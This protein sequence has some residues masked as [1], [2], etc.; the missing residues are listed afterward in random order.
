[1]KSKPQENNYETACKNCLFAIYDGKTQTS[2]QL[3]R[4]EKFQDLDQVLDAYDDEK[5]FFVVKGICNAVRESGWNNDVA[6]EGKVLSEIRPRFDVFVDATG[7]T[8]K[9][10]EDWV[11]FHK[12]VSEQDFTIDWTVFAPEDISPAGRKIVA[13]LLRET[14]MT[15]VETNNIDY[16]MTERLLQSRRAFTVVIDRL[17][18]CNPNMFNRIDVLL[19]QDLKK[20]V[21]YSLDGT[22]AISNLAMHVYKNKLDTMS[23]HDAFYEAF[24]DAM[25]RQLIITEVDE[26]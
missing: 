11:Q 17:C 18:L 8:E 7:I 12:E 24:G 13:S 2:C 19:N 4:I 16:A 14:G 26:G 3:G 9:L 6:D 10:V 21:V 5:E 1:M 23:F 20:F 22:S 15:V 25:E